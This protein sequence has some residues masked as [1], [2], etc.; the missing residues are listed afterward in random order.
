MISAQ[1]YRAKANELRAEALKETDPVLRLVSERLA[2][3]YERLADQLSGA[4]EVAPQDA[5]VTNRSKPG[6][7]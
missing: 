1:H 7:K 3:S 4:D 5:K 2:A 6:N